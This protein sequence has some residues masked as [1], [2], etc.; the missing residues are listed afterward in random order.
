MISKREFFKR[1]FPGE[2]VYFPMAVKF[3]KSKKKIGSTGEFKVNKIPI[4]TQYGTRE[5]IIK[6]YGKE[7]GEFL[8]KKNNNKTYMTA[9]MNDFDFPKHILKQYVKARWKMLDEKHP[10]TEK[11]NIRAIDTYI[12][13]II[14]WDC[15]NSSLRSDCENLPNSKSS[16]KSWGGHSYFSYDR[17]MRVN[18][19]P[20]P[21][22]SKRT[23]YDLPEEYGYI[24]DVTTGKTKSG[25]EVLIGQW[26]WERPGFVNNPVMLPLPDKI[27][28]II[29]DA[30]T[31][32]P[33]KKKKKAKINKKKTKKKFD[34]D[35]EFPLEIIQENMDNYE[36]W[37]CP[38][39]CGGIIVSFGSS[40]NEKVYQL[41][42]SHLKKQPGYYGSDGGKTDEEAE[43]WVRTNFDRW[44]E[45]IKDEYKNRFDTWW[46]KDHKNKFNW[47]LFNDCP[48]GYIQD[49]FI[50][51]HKKNFVI[52]KD[53]EEEKCKICYYDEETCLWKA[54]AKKGIGHSQI[55][56]L[57]ITDEYERFKRETQQSLDEM[58]EETEEQKAFKIDMISKRKLFI[59]RF[60][61]KTSVVNHISFIENLLL[62]DKEQAQSV[63]FNN[64]P[65]NTHLFHFKNGA[66][67]MKKGVMIPRVRE[68]YITKQGYNDY[69]YDDTADY[70]EEIAFIKDI[71]EKL[72]PDPVIRERWYN[73]KGYCFTGEIKEQMM[74]IYL[75][76][77]AD[78]GKSTAVDIFK[79]AFEVYVA[80]LDKNALNDN[81]K[82][83][84][85][86]SSLVGTAYRMLFCEEI[87][88]IGPKLKDLTSEN[89]MVKPL[90]CELMNLKNQAKLEANTNVI[91]D[92]VDVDE[93]MFRRIRQL[94][95]NTRF[96]SD[97][98]EVDISKNVFMKVPGISDKFK[99]LK[100]KCALFKF[101]APYAKKY[102]T[103]QA[104]IKDQGAW[105]SQFDE[106]C[107]AFKEQTGIDDPLENFINNN[108][109]HQEGIPEAGECIISAKRMVQ[110]VQQHTG[111]E[112]VKADGT[113]KSNKVIR[114]KFKSKKYK[115][116]S[117]LIL[118]KKKFPE[119]KGHKG[120]YINI[121][122][123]GQDEESDS[124]DEH[125]NWMN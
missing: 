83:D 117:S 91:V 68:H 20:I 75:G 124:E 82:D 105:K 28:E 92:T 79:N 40:K 109:E 78:N 41:L 23:K 90:Y 2:D 112:Y 12:V 10:F 114:Q 8:L 99:S 96:T 16:T 107:D 110:Y 5:N 104:S 85:T 76:A 66:Y 86:L 29:I 39:K 103:A 100:Y 31:K 35:C 32:K 63:E 37:S 54:N 98:E 125:T 51:Y 49:T 122:Y 94:E 61:N 121:I 119:F 111:E 4:S 95:Q 93:G 64:Q 24:T 46:C 70:T 113:F 72:F 25:V 88:T 34:T 58:P 13:G 52:N 118:G 47:K 3:T 106:F 22:P 120:Y 48:D 123:T 19:V 108:F 115:Y 84:K 45:D 71:W 69:D 80:K 50:K 101:F 18:G 102:Y 74:F 89:I 57:L 1:E 30:Y 14:D 67:D 81:A 97:P 21:R 9:T 17:E 77:G 15:E 33:K 55:F 62:Y 36:E 59:Q 27:R 38:K 11:W 6:L 87:K 26:S 116:K 56:H 44:N 53:Y 7:V 65:S 60:R 73:W 42:L 43:V